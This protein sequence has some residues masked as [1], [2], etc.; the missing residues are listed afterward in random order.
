M[1]LFLGALAAV[2]IAQLV[3]ASASHDLTYS[4]LAHDIAKR[5]A[6]TCKKTAD[7]SNTIPANANRYCAGGVCSFRCRTGYTQSGNSCRAPAS[8]TSCK[9]TSDCSN[10]IPDGANRYCNKG[11]C[12][13]RCRSGFVSNGDGCSRSGSTVTTT[14]AAPAAT[15]C[16]KT[17]D[18][19]NT[20]PANANRY[21]DSGVCS[22]R[23]QSGY[24][25]SGS[26]CIR[27]V[28]SLPPAPSSSATPSPATTPLS[29]SDAVVP[30]SAATQAFLDFLVC[31]YPIDH[32]TCTDVERGDVRLSC[33]VKPLFPCPNGPCNINNLKHCFLQYCLCDDVYD[34]A[35]SY[36]S[37]EASRPTTTS[38]TRP[39]TATAP[40][41]TPVLK[42]TYTGSDFTAGKAFEFFTDDDPTHGLVDYV[43]GTTASSLGL[44]KVTSS[45]AAILA[46]DS[47]STLAYNTKRKS[48]RIESVETYDAGTLMLFDLAHM[49]WG[50]S[51]WPAMWT[52]N[53]PWP[54]MGEIDIIEG[55]STRAFNQMTLHTVPGC[56]RNP[57]VPQTGLQNASWVGNDCHAYSWSYGC[58]VMDWDPAAYGEGFNRAGGGVFA[59]LFAEMG[60]SI[61]RWKRSDIPSDIKN[62][63]PRWKNWGVPVAAFDGSTCDTRTFFQKQRI[64]FDITTCGDM[65]GQDHVWQ[66]AVQ[67][68]SS[69]YPKYGNCAAAVMDPDNF[70]EA[71]FEV[72]YIKVYSV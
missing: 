5:A 33:L 17:A 8:S 13:W 37:L 65:A 58:N 55:V 28:T 63:A 21:C 39:A 16:A 9:A 68:G 20:P 61:W 48:V 57:S 3:S 49:P 34:V 64:T 43:D 27:L 23:C 53:Q 25:Q 71:Y 29:T 56:T 14:T 19:K 46:I 24:S 54:A 18:C 70:K 67:S 51:T 26:S 7:C 32:I 44:T 31:H 52:F 15:A 12:S 36:S 35:G 69:C 62:G 59:L 45:N 10:D 6:A 66:D 41:A 40:A 50:C 38:T 22:W 72:N 47:K 4:P 11:T 30:S 2:S 1:R 42:R 60:I